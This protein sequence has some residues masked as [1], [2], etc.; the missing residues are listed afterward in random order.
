V[1]LDD[2]EKL[3]SIEGLT[4]CWIEEATETEENDLNVIDAGLSADVMPRPRIFMSFN[5][6]PAIPG[7]PF[8]LRR[9]FLDRVPHELGKLAVQ[10]NIAILKTWYRHNHF[11]PP[12]T[13]KLLNSYEVEN[14]ELFEMWAK[15]EWVSLT[16][17]IL[18]PK[19]LHVIDK[20]PENARLI[21]FGLDFGFVDPSACI[22]ARALDGNLYLD[23]KLY[24]SG[25]TNEQLDTELEESGVRRYID[26]IKADSAEPKTIR[27]LA[28]YGWQ[29]TPCEK[30]PD[31]KR[32]AAQ[33]LKGLQIYITA[34]SSNTLRELHSWSWKTN[35]Q[36]DALPQP[37]DG[38]DHT[39]D[40]VCY[41]V[42]RAKGVI[43]PALI[44][45]STATNLKP[46]RRSIVNSELKPLEVT[47]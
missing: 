37:A 3:K 25:L 22:E 1:G 7:S 27:S 18:D 8:W 11:C 4:D 5:P 19:R 15:G 43:D 6:I 24:Q 12:E 17:G 26:P 9:R 46:V 20:M 47:A 21:N 44:A 41:A 42:F 40:A 35:K 2:V 29:I 34:K 36:G 39:C 10:G 28:E 14:P 23:E 13:V 31:F 16:N 38:N 33:H 32:S 45:R 30:G